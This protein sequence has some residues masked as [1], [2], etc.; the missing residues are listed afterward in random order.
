MCC[1]LSRFSLV[2][3][4]VSPWMVARQPPLSIGFSRREYWSGLPCPLPDLSDPGIEHMSPASPA[5]QVDSIPTEP[6]GNLTSFLS[7][8]T[9]IN[10][11]HR[12]T[13]PFSSL[14]DG[15]ERS[16]NLFLIKSNFCTSW[17][18]F[19]SFLALL[20]FIYMLKT[21]GCLLLMESPSLI[22][23]YYG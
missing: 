3:L 7:S 19:I 17:T 9:T 11:Y 1:V 2:W 14:S 12:Q 13:C 23:H 10:Y 21:L 15:D 22:F 16:R 18:F 8:L 4:F 6:R 20:V 5:L